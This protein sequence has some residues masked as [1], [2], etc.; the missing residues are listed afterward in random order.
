[1][2]QSF[3]AIRPVV[4]AATRVVIC[5]SLLVTSPGCAIKKMA[6]NSL[7]NTLSASG[8]TFSSDDD[9]ELVRDAVPF[10]LKTYES[11]LASLPRHRGLLLATCSGFT[12]YSYAFVQSEADRLEPTDYAASLVHRERALK[13]YLRG[14]DYCLRALDIAQPGITARL[15]QNPAAAVARFTKTDVPLLYWTAASWGAAAT[16]GL[17][18]PPLVGD[19]PVVRSLVD[20]ALAL[21]ERFGD[22]AIHEVLISLE[23][24]PE[25]MGGS[26]ARA[27]A[28]F[29][30]AIVLCNGHSAGAYV[31]LATSL[32]LGAQ[33]RQEFVRL[34]EQALA[35][36][37]DA[38][39]S[40]RLANLIAQRRARYLMGRV[41]ELFVPD[42]EVKQP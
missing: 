3:P 19:L 31:T 8:D 40:R 27:R 28:H 15:N 18:R 5:A 14:R 23:A 26:E 39:K 29:D 25:A 13:L 32:A 24:V 16:L 33:D 37:P 30:R 1:M 21:D 9:P 17:D 36:D 4:R 10:A 20:R 7:A 34:L 41:D 35:V 12:Q 11:L 6:L 22:G 42:D 38:D 2:T